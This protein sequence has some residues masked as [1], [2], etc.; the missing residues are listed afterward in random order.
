MPPFRLRSPKLRITENHVEHAC[1]GLLG[2]R[3]YRMLRLQSGLFRTADGRWIR[4]GERGMPDDAALHPE[5]P[6]S[7]REI[8]RPGARLSAEQQKKIREIELGYGLEV[9]V[10]D[11]VESLTGWLAR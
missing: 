2:C 6:G 5:R 9:A 10:V 7:L 8:K 1:L 3:G 11:S 4:C